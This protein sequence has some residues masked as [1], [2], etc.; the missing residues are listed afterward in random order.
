M[1]GRWGVR[2]DQHERFCRIVPGFFSFLGNEDYCFS[3]NLSSV[4]GG[5]EQITYAM[6]AGRL[7]DMATSQI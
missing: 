7:Y 1:S 4:A 2:V 3:R 6:N 5:V